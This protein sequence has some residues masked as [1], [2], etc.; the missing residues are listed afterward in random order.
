MPPAASDSTAPNSDSRHAAALLSEVASRA[1]RAG[2]FGEVRA[3]PDRV[4]CDA[5]ASAA[6]AAYRVECAAGT[7]WVSLVMADRW[8]SHSIEADLLNTGDKLEDLVAEEVAEHGYAGSAVTPCEHYRSEDRLFT[9]RSRIP[10]DPN[11]P[12]QAVVAIQWLLG[13]EACFR[14][15]GDMEAKR[16]D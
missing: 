14:R 11:R 6:P 13:Y 9:F 4:E 12:D 8:Q 7:F 5:L 2:V 16:E 3:L 1:R 15:L 10:I